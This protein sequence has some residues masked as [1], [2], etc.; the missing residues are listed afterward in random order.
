MFFCWQ[1]G[2]GCRAP[3]NLPGIR[4][5]EGLAAGLVPQCPL[6]TLGITFGASFDQNHQ[7]S[8]ALKCK[9]ILAAHVDTKCPKSSCTRL[10]TGIT[11]KVRSEDQLSDH[12]WRIQGH[13]GLGNVL[14]K[15]SKDYDQSGSKGMSAK[16]FHS[17]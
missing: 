1:V 10:L 4:L 6:H 16:H 17:Q 5:P 8:S 2:V 13:N 3:S 9:E 11:T 12:D 15:L 7:P 14:Q